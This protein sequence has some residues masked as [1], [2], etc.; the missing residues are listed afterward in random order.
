MGLQEDRE[1]YMTNDARCKPIGE[2]EVK[3]F[4]APPERVDQDSVLRLTACVEANPLFV[5]VM[6]SMPCPALVL[7]PERQIVFANQRL[8]SVVNANHMKEVLG[9]R[10]G[11][12]VGCVHAGEGPGGC[13]TSEACAMC[14]AVNAILECQRT[15]RIVVQECR[16]RIETGSETAFDFEVVASSFDLSGEPVTICALRDIS[17]EKRRHVLERVF[18]HDVL[19]TAGGIH[20][21]VQLMADDSGK[22]T[23]TEEGNLRL[24][25]TLTERLVH[26][27]RE[28]RQLLLAE[29]GDLRVYPGVVSP[30]DIMV[31]VQTLMANLEDMKDRRVVIAT[32][33]ESG[34]ET[35]P[36]LLQRIL[37]NMTKNALEAT[38][39]GEIVTLSCE[40]LEGE[41]VAFRVHN[42]TVMPREVQ[43]QVF[44]RSFST[45]TGQGHG[46]GTYS[47]KLLGEKY[48]KGKVYFTSREGTGTI[49]TIEIPR[50]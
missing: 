49:F 43:L 39:P 26:E 40:D 30:H 36:D 20:G 22:P 34:I 35:D 41:R 23:I 48:L 2:C 14:G 16:I 50:E 44:N 1:R 18:F 3:T 32:A 38:L 12:V 47:M 46:V 4:H 24:L 21:F 15:G 11:E 37:V 6:E 19:N 33:P 29:S 45:K 27:L 13:G 42:S 28:H 5:Q 9:K 25:V 17:S 8:L 10:P 7:N 31:E